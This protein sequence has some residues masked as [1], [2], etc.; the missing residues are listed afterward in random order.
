MSHPPA[1]DDDEDAT[2]MMS[3]P[4]PA[5]RAPMPAASE[6]DT[7]ALEDADPDATVPMDRGPAFGKLAADIA[8]RRPRP[9]A[10]T[11]ARPRDPTDTGE[12]TQPRLAV[13]QPAPLPLPPKAYAP[14]PQRASYAPPEPHRASYAPPEP[15]RASYHPPEPQRLS[16]AP[17][18]PLP[19][20]RPPSP[21]FYPVAPSERAPAPSSRAPDT[22]PP[23]LRSPPI[24]VAVMVS[25]TVLTLTGLVLLAYLKVRGL[26]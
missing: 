10:G 22:R 23:K 5:A 14:P 8:A 7:E 25:C 24:Y 2:R 12:L 26:W 21:S 11:P 17:P 16:Y 15:H 20:A 18:A 4:L 13:P 1:E 3:R 19:A 9:A 6:L